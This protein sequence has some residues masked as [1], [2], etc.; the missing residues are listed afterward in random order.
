MQP[1]VVSLG[2]ESHP[3]PSTDAN[4][5]RDRYLACFEG[6]VQR[7]ITKNMDEKVN[8]ERGRGQGQGGKETGCWEA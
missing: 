7:S 5:H 3:Q 1:G 6:A 4:S 8:T 2:P